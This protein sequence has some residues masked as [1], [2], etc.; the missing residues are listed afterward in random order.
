MKKYKKEL[1]RLNLLTNIQVF[2]E[3]KLTYM[4][5]SLNLPYKVLDID[6]I[7]NPVK[8]VGFQYSISENPSF[9]HKVDV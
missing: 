5:C 9:I 6:W 1:R 3:E 7:N 2:E 4:Q 8:R